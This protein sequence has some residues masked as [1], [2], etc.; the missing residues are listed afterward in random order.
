MITINLPSNE[1]RENQAID[2]EA[3]RRDYRVLDQSESPF[4][5]GIKIISY[6]DFSRLADRSSGFVFVSPACMQALRRIPLIWD[7]LFAWRV[8]WRAGPNDVILIDGGARVG[9]LIG[10]F[11]YLLPMRRR[12]IVLWEAHCESESRLNALLTRWAYRGY[13]R[14][15]VYSREQIRRHAECLRLPEDRFVF[16]P[17]KANDSQWPPIDMPIG[18]YI[19]SG[20]NSRRDYRTLF[21]AVRGTGIPTIVSATDPKVVKGLDVPAEV[22]LLSANEPAFARLNAGS[23]FVVLPLEQNLVHGAGEAG[24]CNPMWHKKPVVAADDAMASEYIV[25]GD[26]GYV[27]PPGDSEALKR[28]IVALWQDPELCQ[29]MGRRA[30]ERVAA[31]FTHEHFVHRMIR[32][33]SLVG[34]TQ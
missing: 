15:I 22:V 14:I 17:F 5:A 6:T 29:E 2:L 3:V 11:N 33:A 30:H 26:T 7:I 16:V 25:D 13:S 4:A 20:G 28:R 24:V 34:A 31:R 23:R 21:A 12:K 10:L 32:L 18:N 8:F 27:V 9:K 19:F 1:V